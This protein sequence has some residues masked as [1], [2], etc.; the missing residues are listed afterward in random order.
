MGGTPA[1]SILGHLATYSRVWS[2]LS[3]V[4]LVCSDGLLP[5]HKLVLA[6]LSPLLRSA[7]AEADTWDETVSVVMPDFSI[8]QVSRYLADIFTCEDLGQHP[9]INA[10]FGHCVEEVSPLVDIIDIKDECLMPPQTNSSPLAD[11]ETAPISQD[12]ES[13]ERKPEDNMDGQ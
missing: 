7:L 9:E 1:D 12:G 5:A 6:A 13:V 3:D 11:I 8:Q 10:V 4:V 2:P